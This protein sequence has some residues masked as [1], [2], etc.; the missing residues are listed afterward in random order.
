MN[1]GPMSERSLMADVAWLC[2]PDRKGRGSY[3]PGG[4][5]TS[6]W[7]AEQLKAAGLAVQTQQ[8]HSDVR[9]VVGIAK[10]GPKAVIVSAHFDHLG[11]Q[12]GRVYLGADDNASGVA[13]LLAMAR[14]SAS[15]RYRHTVL[16]IGFGAEEAGLVGSR[17]Y[18]TD[19]VWPLQDTLAVINFDMVGRN[20]FEAGANQPNAAAIVGLEDDPELRAAALRAGRQAKLKVIATPAQFLRVFGFHFRTDDWWFRHHGVTAVHFS[21][22]FHRDY[23]QVTDTPDKLVPKQLRAVARTAQGILDYVANRKVQ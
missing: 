16:F 20:F 11:E 17:V 4:V 14:L 10:A 6:E 7:L 1:V 19:P 23:H 13:V 18:V 3:Q 21:T 15:R 22:G 12:S 9:N 8:I 2:H 5:A